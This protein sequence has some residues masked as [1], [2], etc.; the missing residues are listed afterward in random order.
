M[1][2]D[3]QTRSENMSKIIHESVRVNKKKTNEDTANEETYA[4]SYILYRKFFGI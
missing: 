2:T 4:T 3:T 1:E